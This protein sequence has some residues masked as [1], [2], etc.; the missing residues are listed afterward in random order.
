MKKLLLIM[1]LTLISC[2]KNYHRE[3]KVFEC[4]L[5][6]GKRITYEVDMVKGTKYKLRTHRGSYWLNFNDWVKIEGMTT[7]E[8][9]GVIGIKV[10]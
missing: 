4:E 10:Y 1:L 8:I 3:T 2:D 6:S 5:I 7:S 9:P